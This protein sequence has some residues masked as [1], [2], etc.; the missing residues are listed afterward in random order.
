M[1]APEVYANYYPDLVTNLP[2]KDVS[3]TALLFKKGL[4]PGNVK[5]QV[6]SEQTAQDGAEYFLDNMIG[7]P[8][9][10]SNDTGPFE[11]LLSAMEEFT[12]DFLKKLACTI[13]EHL[14]GGASGGGGGT[15]AGAG[16][17]TG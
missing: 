7:P 15:G 9:S 4:F 17:S 3:F 13:R 1:T 5:A 14:K 10:S 16:G 12:N 6:K 2:M 8:I 11:K